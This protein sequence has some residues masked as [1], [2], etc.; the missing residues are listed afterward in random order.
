MLRRTT[1]YAVVGGGEQ[2]IADLERR[3][4]AAVAEEDFGLA[5]TLRD[6]LRSALA[7]RP[8]DMASH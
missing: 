5:A 6:Q 4:A 1:P 8:D 7:I 2:P 3:L